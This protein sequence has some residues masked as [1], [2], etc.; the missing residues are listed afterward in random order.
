MG[1]ERDS[2]KRL[3]SWRSTSGHCVPL[4]DFVP[5]IN[6]ILLSKKIL[7]VELCRA[8]FPCFF[9]NEIRVMPRFCQNFFGQCWVKCVRVS[10]D[11]DKNCQNLG[12]R[13]NAIG[14]VKLIVEALVGGRGEGGEVLSH[15]KKCA[16]QQFA[17]WRF[18]FPVP[19]RLISVSIS[20]LF[21]KGCSCFGALPTSASLSCF[22]RIVE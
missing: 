18:T 1:W 19:R 12:M 2:V 5:K 8:S 16:E 3:R 14:F 4:E 7:A 13:S 6:R 17:Y 11:G 10:Q 15:L 22:H 9:S 21:N 20:H